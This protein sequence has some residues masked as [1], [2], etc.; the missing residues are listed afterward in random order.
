MKSSDDI[1]GLDT[2]RW[3]DQQKIKSRFG[4]TDGPV[5][6]DTEFEVGDVSVEYAR[7]GRS[8]VS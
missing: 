8:K 3:D 2:L 7:S 5:E 4:E 6:D 1:K